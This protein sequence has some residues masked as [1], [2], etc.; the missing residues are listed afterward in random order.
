MRDGILFVGT[1][2]TVKFEEAYVGVDIGQTFGG[3]SWRLAS[4][5]G[6]LDITIPTSKATQII[7]IL[8]ISLISL[9]VGF[10]EVGVFDLK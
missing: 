9:F 10:I 8:H 2:F 3:G 7:Y 5:R 4:R 1:A 6:N